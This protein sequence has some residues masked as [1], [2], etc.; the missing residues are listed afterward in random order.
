[1]CGVLSA[2]VLEE[3]DRFR[4]HFRVLFIRATRVGGDARFGVGRFNEIIA[5]K[6]IFNL[7][8]RNVGQHHAVDFD[9]G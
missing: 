4:G 6:V 7:L 1:M 5:E 3:A 2:F 8:A 9:A